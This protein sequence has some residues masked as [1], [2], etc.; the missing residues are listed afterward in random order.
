[1]QKQIALF[2]ISKLL[3]HAIPIG[4][5]S[6]GKDIRQTTAYTYRIENISKKNEND[7]LLQYNN[8]KQKEIKRAKKR[9][10]FHEDLP[11]DIFYQ[12][13]KDTLHKRGEIS[14]NYHLIRKNSSNYKTT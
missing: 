12:H 3:T 10:Q 14:Y 9:L 4:C 6:I 1:M 11:V 2:F 8:S 13:H 7:L 5:L